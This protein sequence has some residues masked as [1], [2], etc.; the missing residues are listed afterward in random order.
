MN[1][2]NKLLAG[3]E[4]AG[5]AGSSQASSCLSQA[6]FDQQERHASVTLVTCVF[7]TCIMGS[8]QARTGRAYACIVFISQIEVLFPA[9]TSSRCPSRSMALTL[10]GEYTWDGVKG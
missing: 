4:L 1:F 3:S 2:P 5:V 10:F 8:N 9:L 7:Y 6:S